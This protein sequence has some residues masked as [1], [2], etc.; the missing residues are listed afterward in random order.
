MLLALVDLRLVLYHNEDQKLGLVLLI[1][2]P[3]L[4]LLT[5]A[6]LRA[7]PSLFRMASPGG[8]SAG[9]GER[10]I[11]EWLLAAGAR[12]MVYLVGPVI[13]SVLYLPLLARVAQA[14]ACSFVT[15]RAGLGP[16]NSDPRAPIPRPKAPGLSPQ[17]CNPHPQTLKPIHQTRTTKA[18][19]WSLK[20]TT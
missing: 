10:G 4:W 7:R 6:A 11:G 17:A 15:A 13:I 2:L 20:P 8:G 14:V 16:R 1:L 12:V 19:P 9:A 3:F 5:C 18:K